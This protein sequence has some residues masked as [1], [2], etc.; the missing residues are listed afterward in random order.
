MIRNTLDTAAALDH[1]KTVVRDAGVKLTHQRLEIFRELAGAGPTRAELEKAQRRF[2]FDLDALDDD[3]QHL[4]DFYG[5]AEL[6]GQR[7]S[8]DDRRAE[9]LSLSADDLRA[10]AARVLDPARANVVLVGPKA[11]KHESE[12]KS[13]LKSFRARWRDVEP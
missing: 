7:R 9:L 13:L 4:C 1:W 12:I 6:F 3:A 8:P 2:G 5:P 11:T 10:A